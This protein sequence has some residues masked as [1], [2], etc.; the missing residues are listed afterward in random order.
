MKM[1][2]LAMLC[3]CLALPVWAEQSNLTLVVDGVAYSNVVFKTVTPTTVSI[4]HETGTATIPL[5]KLP[6]ELQKQFHYNPTNGTEKHAAFAPNLTLAPPA[7]RRP[8]GEASVSNQA[9]RVSGVAGNRT[10]AFNNPSGPFAEYDKK[11]VKKIQKRWY[12]M[13][14]HYGIYNNTA[15]VTVSFD[16]HADGLVDKVKIT[17]NSGGQILGMFCEKAVVESAPFDPWPEKAVAVAGKDPRQCTFT[18]YY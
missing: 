15:V 5:A 14:D 3:W 9:A 17:D 13:I 8:S 2:R 11:V 4:V 18:F 1:V 6:P 16:L 12:E 10:G 7:V